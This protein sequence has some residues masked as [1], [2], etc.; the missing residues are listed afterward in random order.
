MLKAVEK[1]YV[2]PS[3]DLDFLRF[4]A[5]AIMESPAESVDSA[6]M[7]HTAR[8]AVVP[9]DGDWS[10]VN[11]RQA[12]RE[13]SLAE[14]EGDA[15]DNVLQGDLITSATERCYLQTSRRSTGAIGFQDCAVVETADAL[16][17]APRERAQEVNK[18]FERLERTAT[19]SRTNAGAC[20]AHGATTKAW[21]TE[22]ASR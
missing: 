17:V 3:A 16:L 8:A 7:E 18:L 4:N 9:F 14:G 11:P 2:G 6:F 10:D 12:L 22:N 19:L 15:D 21:T 20:S 13:V 5:D 1:V